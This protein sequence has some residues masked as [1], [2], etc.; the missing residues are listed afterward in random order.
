MRL[1]SRLGV[2]VLCIVLVGLPS[3]GRAAMSGRPD[4]IA[5]TAVQQYVNEV[6]YMGNDED[7]HGVWLQSEA[8]LLAHHQGTVP[9]PAAGIDSSPVSVAPAASISTGRFMR[10]S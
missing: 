5:Q 9:L 8:G 7:H 1:V 10:S 3:T 4:P 6:A 2:I